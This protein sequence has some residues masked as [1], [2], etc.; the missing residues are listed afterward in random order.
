VGVKGVA[1]EREDVSGPGRDQ[2]V[3][4]LFQ[5]CELYSGALKRSARQPISDADMFVAQLGLANVT[6]AG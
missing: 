3:A 6:A 4:F 1:T 2:R 5:F